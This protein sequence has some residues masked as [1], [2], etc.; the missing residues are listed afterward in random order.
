MVMQIDLD[1]GLCASMSGPYSFS[2][3]R[4]LILLM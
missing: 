3:P 4:E 1:E 2:V